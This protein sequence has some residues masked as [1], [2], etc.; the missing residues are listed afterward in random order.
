MNKKAP[1]LSSFYRCQIQEDLKKQS[2]RLNKGT[3]AKVIDGELDRKT[4]GQLFIKLCYDIK[5]LPVIPTIPEALVVEVPAISIVT[6]NVIDFNNSNN[7]I[8]IDRASDEWLIKEKSFIATTEVP[9]NDQA[10][11]ILSH[12]TLCH[13]KIISRLCFFGVIEFYYTE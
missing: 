7:T 11:A 3:L 1:H 13:Q 12:V 5:L 10:E 9:S 6:L 4:N 2:V 8:T